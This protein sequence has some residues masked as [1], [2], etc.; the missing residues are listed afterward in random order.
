MYRISIPNSTL[1]V[2]LKASSRV[3]GVEEGP[4][5]SS[6]HRTAVRWE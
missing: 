6:E 5:V 2:K 1:K 3:V 4:D